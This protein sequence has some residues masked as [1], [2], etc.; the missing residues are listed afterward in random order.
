[1]TAAEPARTG[2]PVLI[3]E[4]RPPQQLA[5][6]SSEE[7]RRSAKLSEPFVAK[8][9]QAGTPQKKN[10]KKSR[11][12]PKGEVGKKAVKG[13]RKKSG[14]AGARGTM[15]DSDDGGEFCE[16]NLLQPLADKQSTH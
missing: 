13:T 3:S 10:K 5:S 16:G 7:L 12:R 4:H 14:K 9:A 6:G 2:S 11:S 15:R 8:G 1:M